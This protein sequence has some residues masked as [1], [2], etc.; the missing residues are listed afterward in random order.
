MTD[1][2]L[3]SEDSEVYSQCFSFNEI[4]LCSFCFGFKGKKCC[5]VYTLDAVSSHVEF[6][7][8]CSAQG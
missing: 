1:V 2:Y 8:T 3:P 5:A 6:A 4:C 7:V